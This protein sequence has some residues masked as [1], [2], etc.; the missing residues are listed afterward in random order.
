MSAAPAGSAPPLASSFSGAPPRRAS[1]WGSE[2]FLLGLLVLLSSLPYINI[3]WNGFVYDDD[4]QVLKNPYIRDFSH[5][6]AIFTTT[7]WSYAGGARGVT[8]YYRPLMTLTYLF[9]HKVFGYHPFGFHLASIALNTAVVC[10]LFIVTQRIFQN[11]ALAFVA[12]ALFALHPIHTEAVD[13]IAAVTDLELAFFF[14]LSFWFFLRLEGARGRQ[15]VL[16]ECGM[17]VSFIL[18]LLSKEPAAVLPFLAIFYEHACREDRN[19]TSWPQKLARYGALWL[20][21]AGYLALRVR[22]FGFAPSVSRPHMPLNAVAFSAVALVGQYVEK[23]LWPVRLSAYYVFPQDL[24]GLLPYILAGCAALI[25]CAL[26]MIYFWKKERKVWFGFVWFFLALAPVLN[27]RWMPPNVFAERY[28]Y[29]PSIGLCWVGAWACLRA[30][31]RAESTRGVVWRRGIM[32]AAVIVAA[33]CAARIVTRNPVWKNDLTFYI[34]TL[35]ASPGAA[36]MRNNLGMYYWAHADLKDAGEQWEM[37]LAEQPSSTYLLD[38][39]GLL[40]IRQKRFAEAVVFFERALAL[41]PTDADAHTG[42][43]EAY[44]KM[45]RRD[46]A[47]RELTEAVKLAP[48]DVR[49]LVRLGELYFDEGKYSQAEEEFKA[50]IRALPTLRGWFGLGLVHWVEGERA[51]AEQAFKTALRLDPVDSRPYFMLGLL[52][53]SE[54]RT[55]E[56]IREYEKGLKIDPENQTALAALA[57]LKSQASTPAHP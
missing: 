21:L 53:G 20:I 9:C 31:R 16:L 33:L 26:L 17:A 56:A 24:A 46:Q 11:R 37:A 34:Q 10:L 38:N 40:R 27:A 2:R 32:T 49:P 30:W 1:L 45:G 12:A 28:L 25:A 52:Y 14:L 55:A 35:A 15:L 43:G 42:L 19:L 7:V 18:A 41:T 48:L 50:S 3:L 29:L 22:L 57:K 6:N 51:G 44:Q 23:M 5:L 54:N 8:N 47:E 4:I 39:M 36:D 13:W